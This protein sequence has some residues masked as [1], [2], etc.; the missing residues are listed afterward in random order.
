M[1]EWKTGQKGT[2]DRLEKRW[3]G[4]GTGRETGTPK[5]DAEL[6]STVPQSALTS[7]T[8]FHLYSNSFVTVSNK[9]GEWGVLLHPTLK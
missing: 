6:C 2:W 9:W 3:R 1:G 4:G 7:Q 5:S 8:S